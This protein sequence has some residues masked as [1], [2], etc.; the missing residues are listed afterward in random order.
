MESCVVQADSKK[1]IPC[2][3]VD[4]GVKIE[5]FKGSKNEKKN[6]L[7]DLTKPPNNVFYLSVSL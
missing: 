3:R 5:F 2:E 7:N 6:Q 1:P 4:Y